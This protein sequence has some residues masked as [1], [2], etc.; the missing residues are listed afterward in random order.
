MYRSGQSEMTID[1]T[2]AGLERLICKALTEDPCDLPS[3]CTVSEP[4]SP[5]GGVG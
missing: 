3:G 2:E 4:P 1:L 5:S